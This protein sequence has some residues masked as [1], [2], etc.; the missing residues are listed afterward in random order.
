VTTERFVNQASTALSSPVG[1][2]DLMITVDSAAHF[3]NQPEFRVRVGQELIL[4]TGV[5][6]TTWTVTRGVEGT[7]ATSHAAGTVV[8]A[9]LTGGSLDE[10]RTEIETE[11]SRNTY[12]AID[13]ISNDMLAFRDALVAATNAQKGLQLSGTTEIQLLDAGSSGRT[14]PSNTRLTCAP[15]TQIKFNQVGNY[16]LYSLADNVTPL[17]WTAVTQSVCNVIIPVPLVQTPVVGEVLFVR[18]VDNGGMYDVISIGQAVVGTT[19]ISAGTLYGGSSTLDGLTLI[20]NVDGAGPQTLVLS[21]ATNVAT[22]KAFLAAIL[23]K[24]PA[25]NLCTDDAANHHLALSA[26]TSIVVGSGT[27]NTLLG[28]VAG[29]ATN[30]SIAVD[31]PVVWPLPIGA[32]IDLYVNTPHDIDIDMRGGNLYGAAGQEFE[33]TAGRRYSLRNVNYHYRATDP[34]LTVHTVCALDIGTRDSEIVNVVA[35]NDNVGGLAYFGMYAQAT[36][37]CVIRDC[38]FTGFTEQG[39]GF[40]DSYNCRSINNWTVGCGYAHVITGDFS[41]GVTFGSIDCSIEG[42]GDIGSAFSLWVV[43]A[44]RSKISNFSSIGALQNGALID[45]FPG[46]ITADTTLTACSFVKAPVG[47]YVGANVTGTKCYSLNTNDCKNGIVCAGE[48]EVY[49]WKM[50]TSEVDDAYSFGVFNGVG[51]NVITGFDLLRPNGAYGLGIVIG[52]TG[53]TK[54]SGGSIAMGLGDICVKLDNAAGILYIDNVVFSGA[55]GLW[56]NAGTIIV[57][58]NCDFSGCSGGAFLPGAGKIIFMQQGGVAT[59]SWHGGPFGLLASQMTCRSIEVTGVLDSD[60][61]L[62]C[63]SW[64]G[65]EWAVYNNTTG[66]FQVKFTEYPFIGSGVVL[67]QGKTTV[68]R[69]GSNGAMIKVSAAV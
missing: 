69:I 20:L 14:I 54:L 16:A 10:M 12:T 30:L 25:L 8:V 51:P 49:G 36:E 57:G 31:R 52:S 26:V 48:I 5:A 24:W 33:V 47:V 68:V 41:T 21:K 35:R 62:N 17:G 44:I 19:D 29:A 27:A 58:P 40:T 45:Y 56:V 11:I 43:G 50:H 32:S 6:G 65:A 42:G 34:H 39:C 15:G 4:I 61:L 67:D 18:V 2:G 59:V 9:V 55:Y 66:A 23:A 28:L 64:V 1:F 3:P 13:G 53:V 38:R 22:K 7:T 37:R 46:D 63:P 60:L